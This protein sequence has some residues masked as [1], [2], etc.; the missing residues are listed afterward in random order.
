MKEDIELIKEATTRHWGER[1][2]ELVDLCPCC[3][4]WAAFDVLT[5]FMDEE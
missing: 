2:E 4:A 1:C 3:R 5:E